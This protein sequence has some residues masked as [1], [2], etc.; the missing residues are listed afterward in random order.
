MDIL[1]QV[2][3]PQLLSNFHTLKQ[4]VSEWIVSIDS[5][6]YELQE[7]VKELEFR[8]KQLEEIHNKRIR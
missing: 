4:S 6:Q 5:K 1:K 8:L 7:N 3:F 2:K